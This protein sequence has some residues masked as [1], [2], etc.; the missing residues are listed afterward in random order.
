V[1]RILRQRQLER[2]VEE[3]RT[4]DEHIELLSS[5]PQRTVEKT[6]SMSSSSSTLTSDLIFADRSSSLSSTF[7]KLRQKLGA[8]GSSVQ[9]SGFPGT[10]THYGNEAE[11]QDPQFSG[12]P[13]GTSSSLRSYDK[14]TVTPLNDIGECRENYKQG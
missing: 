1:D 12:G 8:T 3:I 9:M 10:P 2:Q 6:T 5:S 13:P 14:P 4:G 7:Q 11:Y